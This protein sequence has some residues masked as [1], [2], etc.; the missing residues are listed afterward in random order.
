LITREL[1]AKAVELNVA[2]NNSHTPDKLLTGDILNALA[3]M[4]VGRKIHNK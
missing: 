3:T 1:L 2:H 4:Y